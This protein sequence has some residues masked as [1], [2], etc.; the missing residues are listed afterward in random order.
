MVGLREVYHVQ[1]PTYTKLRGCAGVRSKCAAERCAGACATRAW[2]V[3]RGRRGVAAARAG[4]HLGWGARL[5]SELTEAARA[6]C[7]VRPRTTCFVS[8][9]LCFVEKN[10]NEHQKAGSTNKSIRDNKAA[11]SLWISNLF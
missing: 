8:K 3:P 5:T 2:R 4:L 9:A 7:V 10:K 11:V 6:V 1:S